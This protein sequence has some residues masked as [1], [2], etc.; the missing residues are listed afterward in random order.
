MRTMTKILFRAFFRLWAQGLAIA[1]VLACG[2]AIFLMA[3]G[4]FTALTET[5]DAYY[6]R[7][8]F[9]D[10]FA[11]LRR[12]PKTLEPDI[13]AIEGVVAVQTRV[14]GHAILDLPNRL[15]SAAGLLISLPVAGEPRLNLPLLRSGRFPDPDATEEVMV[16]EPFAAANGFL[17]GDVFHANLNGRMRPLTITGTALTPE[18]IYTI[19]PGDMMPDNEGF[20]ILWM[21]EPAL[22]AAFDMAGAFNDVSLLLSRG[23]EVETVIDTLDLLL[24]PFGIQGAHDR[25]QQLSNAFIDGEL[26]QLRSMAYVMP[27]VFFGISIFLVNMVIGRIVAL[28]RSEIGLM[29]AL[30]YTDLE[31][32]LHYVWLA[33]LIGLVGVAAGV[34]AGGLLSHGLAVLYASFFSFPYLIFSISPDIYIFSAALGLGAAMA[35]AARSARAAARLAPA[36]AMSPPTPPAYSHSLFDRVLVLLRPSQPTMMIFRN[37]TR[38]PLRAGLTALGIALAVAVLV[39]SSFF[40]D[41]LDEMIDTAF[42]KANRQDAMLILNAEKPDIAIEEIRRLPG[43]LQ[44]EGAQ[45]HSAELRNGHLKKRVAV[46]GRPAAAD[47]SRIVGA[48]GRVVAA[49]ADGLLL[50]QRLAGQLDVRPGDTVTVEFLTGLR[51]THEIAVAGKVTSYIGLAAF[52]EAG[53]LDRLMR[54]APRIGMANLTLDAA[55]TDAFHAAVKE[56]PGLA[57]TVMLGDTLESFQETIEQNITISTIIYVTIAVLIAVGVTYNSARIQLSER[58]R[59]LASLR[60]LGVSRLEV[61]YI[62]IGETALLALFA[63]PLGWLLGYG[64]AGAMVAGFESDLYA[65]P[66]VL[67]RDTF[68]TS[69]LVVLAASA[70]SALLVRR[71]LDNLDIIEVMKTRE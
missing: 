10:V 35:G 32:S 65:I 55:M 49:P 22:A 2:V 24:D 64:L 60:V 16:N 8:R 63:Q 27:P 9:A 59:D 29:K 11:T 18:Y 44:V 56:L 70:V 13:A 37:I 25:T 57:G 36:V 6:E 17:P 28:D 47:L 68:V 62:L 39:A 20:G 48:D 30:G 19:G 4:M 40:Q 12:A 67:N 66:L 3:F 26:K 1:L 14:T 42:Y 69:S 71:R 5:R 38:W 31:V 45:I 41:A 23:A 51:E 46:E 33:G 15:E 54:R 58:A 53:A 52:M 43:V 61:S 21:P 7:N 50:S 34:T